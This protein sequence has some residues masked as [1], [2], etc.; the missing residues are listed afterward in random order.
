MHRHRVGQAAP[1]PVSIHAHQYWRAMPRTSLS[2]TPVMRFQ[3]TPTNTGGRCAVHPVRRSDDEC[4]NPRPPI[5]AG[6][7]LGH[8]HAAQHVG[9]SIHAHQYWRAMP[10]QGVH[11][12]GIGVVSIHAHQYWR[13]MLDSGLPLGQAGLVSIHA[14]QYWRAM[15]RQREAA[16]SV[17]V[18][19]IHAHQYW[20]AM[21]RPK[22]A[23]VD[24]DKVSIHA[25]QY[26]RAMP[27]HAGRTLWRHLFQSTPTNT[28]GRCSRGAGLHRSPPCFNPRPPI[29]AGD[30]TL[31]VRP[32]RRH[33]CFNPRPPI[34]AGDAPRRPR[35]RQRRH[36]SIHAHQY[37][38]AMPPRGVRAD[39][40]PGGF[41]PRP[42]ILAGDALRIQHTARTHLFPSSTRT[43][44]FWVLP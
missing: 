32:W 24:A 31:T 12:F 37:W 44:F 14:H 18:V 39:R 29:L 34:L 41:N 26:W 43:L 3:S 21:Q 2:R 10:A 4:F 19:S 8:R 17:C 36:V 30:A 42:P 11:T 33:W 28:G 35:A 16:E 9:V 23:L 20:R 38:R 7:A 25:H 1:A 22:L 27:E 40:V 6:D 5:L 13:A 15:P